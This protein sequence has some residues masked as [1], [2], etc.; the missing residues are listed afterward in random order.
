LYVALRQSFR[1]RI[2]LS[3]VVEADVTTD[4]VLLD[5]E[6]PLSH[7]ALWHAVYNILKII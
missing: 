2:Q 5:E 1:F 3:S 7:A 6:W 4:T